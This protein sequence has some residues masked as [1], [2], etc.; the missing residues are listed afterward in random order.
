MKNRTKNRMDKGISF[1]GI[2]LSCGLIG[3][4]NEKNSLAHEVFVG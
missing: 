3:D 1:N 2:P 4:Y